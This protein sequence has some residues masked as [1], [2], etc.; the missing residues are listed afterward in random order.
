MSGFEPNASTYLL[1]A[2]VPPS[3]WTGHVPFAFWIIEAMAPEVLVELGTHYGTSFLAFCQAVASGQRGTRAFAVDTWEGDEHSGLYGEEVHQQLSAVVQDKYPGFAQLMRMRFDDATGYF[4]DGGIDL[5][6]IDGLHTYEA[7]KHDFDT[8]LPKMSRRGV[9]L[10]HDTMVRERGFG[11][12]KLWEE[13]SARYPAFEFTHTHGLGVLLVGEQ[14]P[15]ALQALCRLAGSE[16]E[17]LVQQAFEALGQR[18]TYR[19]RTAFLEEKYADAEK[20]RVHY[21]AVFERAEA[22]LA[23]SQAREAAVQAELEARAAEATALQGSIAQLQQAIEAE[24]QAAQA[25]AEAMETERGG[26]REQV[27]LLQAA[28]AEAA[29]RAASLQAE[30]EAAQARAST[31]EAQYQAMLAQ[32]TTLEAEREAARAEVAALQARNDAARAESS[33]LQAEREA[34]VAHIAAL[35]A[36]RDAVQAQVDALSQER[37]EA[38]ALA[39][40]VAVERQKELARHETERAASE[41]QRLAL[42]ALRD[43]HAALAGRAAAVESARHALL[44]TVATRDAELAAARADLRRRESLLRDAESRVAL[45]QAEVD[46]LVASRS[47]RITAPMRWLRGCLAAIRHRRRLPAYAD[48]LRVPDCE[49]AR[50]YPAEP[51]SLLEPA[52]APP[53]AMS[54]TAHHYL[55][56]LFASDASRRAPEYLPASTEPPPRPDSLRAKAIAFYLPQFHPFE[57]NEAWWGKGFTEWTNVTKAVPQFLGHHQPQLPADL[58]FYDLRVPDV[59]RQQVGM[60]RQYGLHGFAFHYYWFAGKRL[61]EKPLDLYLAQE[62]IDFPF[63]LCW[64][65]ENWTRRWDGHDSEVLIS[66]VH[67]PD[68]DLA[69]IRDLEPYLRDRRYIR[70][71]GK[72]LLIVYRPSILPDPAAT[73]KRWREHCR[74]VG[75]GELFIA[76]VQ[77]DTEDPRE[78][79]FDAAM[80]FPPHKLARGFEPINNSLDIVNP[81]YQGNV[82]HY[83]AIVDSA[84]AWPDKGFPLIRSVFPGWDNEARRPGKGYTFAYATPA[85]YREWLDFAV[86]YA[87]RHPVG[88]ERIVMVN[89]WNEWAEGAKLEPDRRF[90]HAFLQATREVLVHRDSA[91]EGATEADEGAP[92]RRRIVVVS[93][94]AHPHGA[95]YLSLNL[96]REL[97]R[98]GFEVEA[99]LLGEGSLLPEFEATA[100]VHRLSDP[101]G[102]EG[103]ALARRLAASG[104]RHVIAN[105]AVSGAWVPALAGAGLV[106]VSL[107]HELPGVLAQYGLEGAAADI[108]RHAH[109]VVFAATAVRDGFGT[110]APVPAEKVRLRPQGIYK[111]NRYADAA[112]RASARREIRDALGIPPDSKIMLGVGYADL[113]KGVDLFVESAAQLAAADPGFHAVWMGHFDLALE[114]SLRKR[115]KALG[116]DDRIHFP[117]RQADTDPWYAGADLLALTSR[118]DPFPSVVMEALDVGV[119]VVAF[120]GT[121]GAGELLSR[122]GGL[123]V[124]TLDAGAFA[125]ACSGL[126]ADDARREAMGREGRALVESGFSFR[127]YVFDLL[128]MLG[129][130]L[131]RV[132]VVVPNYNYGHLID[133][134][135]RSI[136]D[137]SVP[138]YELIVLDDASTDDS[139]A[140]IR[141]LRAGIELR[142]IPSPEN[143]GSVFRQWARGLE[144]ATGDFVWIAEADDLS[145]PAFLEEALKG[146]A[147]PGVVMSYTQS[148]QIGPSGEVLAPDYL[149]YT[150]DIC[151]QRWTRPFESGLDE[152]IQSGL[153]VKNTIPN[154]SA[155]VFRTSAL[156]EVLSGHLDEI[157]SYRVAGDWVVYLRMLGLGRLAYSPKALN[158]HRRHSGSVTL[159]GDNVPHLREVIR[160]QRWID[161][162]FGV[163]DEQREAAMEYVQV[164]HRYFGLGQGDADGVHR[165]ERFADL[166]GPRR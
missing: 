124:P 102:E 109:R 7:V 49:D 54:T 46:R 105:T 118:E 99:V 131:P 144:A 139:L 147:A 162:S 17:T 114:P 21:K 86:G 100:T 82:V 113:R 65:N 88:G 29:A 16:G 45:R 59:F 103:R 141:A 24:R 19:A 51:P 121:G 108:A 57:E 150:A 107:V 22:A 125:R 8:W 28:Q 47:W 70:V 26:A 143:S 83:Q 69:F 37:R 6:H 111:R 153:A 23:E 84:K 1:P 158:L 41:T 71:D 76:M 27:A 4:S 93:H 39:H 112:G 30:G 156:A 157:A 104:F 48:M 35:Q 64:A 163:P 119:P 152:E 89:A 117:G 115:V 58:G 146:F 160:V 67:G 25:A 73:L 96:C 75:I 60:A 154:V 165:D 14:P 148:Q 81:D 31:L 137:Q 66:Q 10:F 145:D 2:D 136:A 20:F 126:L 77:F 161:E 44:A 80:E 134:R 43:E 120:A 5:L 97:A 123:M 132:S 9:V 68:N 95:Q 13:L 106:V 55:G 61:M 12:W 128:A 159:G 90:G 33:A 34:A 36:D 79:G 50:P 122:G 18:V 40:A 56:E 135:L 129:I 140:R 151:R 94:D 15:E 53:S 149:D 62:D 138:Y 38:L 164:L 92:G 130:D 32:A 116:M 166:L 42:D 98:M 3:A 72:P 52:A 78:H 87:E 155:V 74:A 110:V 101:A 63:C 127:K 85:R 133:Q 91:D 142:L 11:V